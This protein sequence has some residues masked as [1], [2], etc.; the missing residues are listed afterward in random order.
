MFNKADT[1]TFEG[2]A[3]QFYRVFEVKATMLLIAI[4]MTA[5]GFIELKLQEK[6]IPSVK[7][8]L[9]VYGFMVIPLALI[10]V[11][12]LYPMLLQTVL[13]FFPGTHGTS[14]LRNHAL[15][16]TLEEL[17][18]TLPQ[19]AIETLKNMADCNLQLF[20]RTVEIWQAYL[21]L[22]GA[23]ALLIGIY[24]TLNVLGEK[25]KTK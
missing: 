17:S 3:T 21:I 8:F 6:A 18:T 9:P 16:G 2:K 4:F 23:T 7:R 22:F 15:R 25:R 20:G 5:N 24:V 19:E 14:L 13:S 11:F 10:F 12:N 1:T